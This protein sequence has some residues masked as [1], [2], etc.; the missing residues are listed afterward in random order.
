MSTM[1][2][3]IKETATLLRR[4][5]LLE[6]ADSLSSVPALTDATRAATHEKII[7]AHNAAL[8]YLPTGAYKNGAVAQAAA[9]MWEVLDRLPPA[10]DSTERALR[11]SLGGAIQGAWWRILDIEAA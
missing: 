5:G 8:D 3:A 2:E 6:H 9:A 4:A 7:R 10:A 11:Q 1:D